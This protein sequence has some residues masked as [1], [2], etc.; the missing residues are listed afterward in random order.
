MA[1]STADDFWAWESWVDSANDPAIGFP[2]QSLPYCAFVAP[3]NSVARPRLGVAIGSFLLDLHQ[4]SA[5]GQLE[6][7]ASA[8][9]EACQ[10][11]TLNALMLCGNV[12][13]S[14]LRQAL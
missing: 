1:I 7:L 12:A 5:T 2:L 4:L 10:A 13:T 3:S 14:S 6:N 9:R 11:P 8:T